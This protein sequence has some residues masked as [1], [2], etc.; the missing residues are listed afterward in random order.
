MHARIDAA[1]HARNLLEPLSPSQLARV[2]AQDFLEGWG[3]LPQ[4]PPIPWIYP[5][6]RKGA[7]QP[8]WNIDNI[9]T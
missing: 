3:V 9:F 7:P 1:L 2:I 5:R 4:P 6:G 8:S